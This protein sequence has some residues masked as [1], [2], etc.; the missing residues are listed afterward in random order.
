D[1]AGSGGGWFQETA[2]SFI[3]LV[4]I[5]TLCCCTTISCIALCIK[6][7]SWIFGHRGR[8]RRMLLLPSHHQ[9]YQ[10]EFSDEDGEYFYTRSPRP[11]IVLGDTSARQRYGCGLEASEIELREVPFGSI[12]EQR[13]TLNKDHGEAA[14]EAEL[15]GSIGGQPPLTGSGRRLE[16]DATNTSMMTRTGTPS[17]NGEHCDGG[18]SDSDGS[19]EEEE[20]AGEEREEHG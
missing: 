15:P 1:G 18:G 2:L 10:P 20:E 12:E 7:A 5:I 11:I 8:R 14:F 3:G 17:V 4:A 16:R 9:H 6:L 13:R 19:S